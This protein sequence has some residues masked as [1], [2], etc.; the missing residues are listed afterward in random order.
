MPTLACR[1]CGR[2]VYTT[3]TLETLF[4]EERRCPRCGAMLDVDRRAESRRKAGRRSSPL[5]DPGPPPAVE[6]RVADRRLIQRRRDD[7][8]ALG[9]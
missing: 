6:R 3:A 8:A 7:A 5:G 4:P 2:V 9:A 1:T